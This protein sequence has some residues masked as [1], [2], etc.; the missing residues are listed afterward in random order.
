MRFYYST[1]FRAA[2]TMA[3]CLL[4]FRIGSHTPIPH[5]NKAVFDT[6]FESH[7]NGV[8]QLVNIIGGGSLSRM[9][10]F[11]LSIM[12]YITASIVIF[13]AQLMSDRVKEFAASENG[14]IKLEQIKRLLTV[15]LVFTQSMTLSSILLS[16]NVNGEPLATVDGFTFY[17]STF[18]S[19]LT[20]TFI[21]VWLANIMTF[22]GFG[23]G[24]SLIIMFGILSSM[25]SNFFTIASM[26]DA[27]SATVVS[28][29]AL[30]A[31]ILFSFVMVIY[32]ENA[33][34]RIATL[35]ND[36][37]GG[38]RPSYVTFKAN[39]IGMMPPI[40]AA[41]VISMFVTTASA[42][43]SL[44]PDLIVQVKNRLVGGTP[45]FI[46]LFSILTFC[47]GFALKGTMLNPKKAANGL[48]MSG[49]VIRSLRVGAETE[50]YLGRLFQALT[51]IACCYLVILCTIPEMINAYLGIPF[52]LGGTSILIMVSTASEMRKNIF[53]MMEGN[54]YKKVGQAFLK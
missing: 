11:S 31:I 42:F 6:L 39:P 4:F 17:V 8:L 5:I 12:P 50:R 34:R 23:A 36:K 54:A 24:T 25:P 40:F 9:S 1:F 28:V 14:K 20:G 15:F 16:Q 2:I 33:G 41:I 52:Y 37:Y 21:V 49:Q 44:M 10:V 48:M 38:S 46:V 27:G 53:G 18:L 35:K 51:F 45:E 7:Q 30:I 26:V 22:V 13:V 19:L 29:A 32:F 3:V 43:S 47:F